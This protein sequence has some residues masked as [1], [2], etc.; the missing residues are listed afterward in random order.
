MTASAELEA[1]ASDT[2][3]IAS[4][5]AN[6]PIATAL[7]DRDLRYIAA[8]D[9]WLAA[10]E[11]SEIAAELRHPQIG[12]VG[13]AALEDLQRRTLAGETVEFSGAANSASGSSRE[14]VLRAN[15]WRYGP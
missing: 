8:N 12:I 13:A 11:L 15:P 2:D 4:F 3:C 5:V 14:R 6:L 1:G 7:F 9:A 10:F